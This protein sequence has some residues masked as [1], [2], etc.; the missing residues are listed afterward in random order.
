MTLQSGS[1]LVRGRDQ[2]FTPLHEPLLKVCYPGEGRIT[3]S[4]AGIFHQVHLWRG[5]QLV[6]SETRETNASV[7]KNNLCGSS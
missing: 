7:L 2:V 1:Y 5:P 3:L 4:E 6:V